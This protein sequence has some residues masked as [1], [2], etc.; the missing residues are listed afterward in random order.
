MYRRI[1]T[2]AI[3]ATLASAASA[4]PAAA[5]KSRGTMRVDHCTSHVEVYVGSTT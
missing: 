1:A 5:E 2:S 3:L 4:T